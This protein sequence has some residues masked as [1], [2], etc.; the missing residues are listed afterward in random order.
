MEYQLWDDVGASDNKRTNHLCGSLYDIFPPNE[1]IKKV[2]KLEEWNTACIV[3]K[4]QHV[5]HWLNGIKIMERQ[6]KELSNHRG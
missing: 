5:E 6:T 2:N 3:C 1:S 4:C